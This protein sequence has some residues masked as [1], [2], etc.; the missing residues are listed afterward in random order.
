MRISDI[1]TPTAATDATT[2]QYVDNK[3]P[4][5][6]SELTNDTGYITSYTETDPTVPAWAKTANKPSY[7]AA[8]VGATT[9]TDVASMIAEAIGGVQS[10]EVLVVE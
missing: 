6:V 9:S 4:K 3:I 2:K 5:K 1:G 8:E 10:F 7:T